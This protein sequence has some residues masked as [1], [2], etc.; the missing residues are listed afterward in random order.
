MK[1]GIE[2]TRA[3]AVP[4]G[5]SFYWGSFPGTMCLAANFR[6]RFA[7]F[8]VKEREVGETFRRSK[9][10][11]VGGE[12]GKSLGRSG[13]RPYRALGEVL[14]SGQWRVARR[15]C[16]GK[17]GKM[18]GKWTGFSHFETAFSHLFPHVSTQVVDFPHICNVR[19]FSDAN[20]A[21]QARHEIG[22]PK[23]V[24][25]SRETWSRMN[26]NWGKAVNREQKLA[27][28]EHKERKRWEIPK[29]RHGRAADVIAFWWRFSSRSVR[30]C[31]RMF[32]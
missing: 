1:P 8:R 16:M 27:A 7:T 19:T 24:V 18:A 12:A 25:R 20:L 10:M 17:G 3:S 5:T 21:S 32:A 31:S 2:V 14:S 28:K 30:L 9:A 15:V 29:S 6:G 11:E 4:Y 13:I 26:A 23:G 22:A